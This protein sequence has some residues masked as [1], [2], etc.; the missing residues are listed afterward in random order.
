M[1]YYAKTNKGLREV[2]WPEVVKAYEA[3]HL[4]FILLRA[5]KVLDFTGCRSIINLRDAQKLMKGF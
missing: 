1:T 4:G 2:S 3:K 5:H